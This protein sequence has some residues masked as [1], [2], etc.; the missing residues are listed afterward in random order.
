MNNDEKRILATCIYTTVVFTT[1]LLTFLDT[2]LDSIL[3]GEVMLLTAS[4]K[5]VSIGLLDVLIVLS[6]MFGLS[7][8][9][10]RR[11]IQLLWYKHNGTNKYSYDSGNTYKISKKAQWLR[12]SLLFFVA[13]MFYV[14]IAI[15]VCSSGDCILKN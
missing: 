11:G 7:F 8:Y 5:F 14:V 6:V 2:T 3:P 12:I 1:L 9:F 15:S 4:Y 13:I 10:K